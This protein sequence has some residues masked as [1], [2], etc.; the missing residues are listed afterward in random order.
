[1]DDDSDGIII[2]KK[3]H[4]EPEGLLMGTLNAQGIFLEKEDEQ[5]FSTKPR[6]EFSEELFKAGGIEIISEESESRDPY[7]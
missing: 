2:D 3:T 6:D 5:V 7:L 4:G 1:M